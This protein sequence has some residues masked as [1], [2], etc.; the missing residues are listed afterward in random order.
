MT[1][2]RRKPTKSSA[3]KT[4]TAKTIAAKKAGAATKPVT[5][6]KKAGTATKPATAAKK[7]GATKASAARKPAAQTPPQGSDGADVI[8]LTGPPSLLRATVSVENAVDQR[9]SVRGLILHRSGQQALTGSGAAV[10]APGATADVPVAFRLEQDTPPGEYA[11][12]VEVGGVRREAL[13]RVEPDLSM[14]VSPRRILAEVGRQAVTLTVTNDG[15]LT[16]PLA[17]VVRARTNDG[18]AVVRAHIDDGSA[19]VR[20][21]TDDGGPGPGPDVTLTLTATTTLAP[22][23]TTVLQSHLTVPAELDPARRHTARI[24]V[25]TADLDVIILPR[26]PSE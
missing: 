16:I 7:A 20:A 24:P 17:A 25:G 14:H 11:A 15:N 18:G 6:T 5:A 26:D 9:V 23:S 19:V 22:G 10:I 12:E 2:A 4:T 21:G 13:L 3:A 1:T 8:V